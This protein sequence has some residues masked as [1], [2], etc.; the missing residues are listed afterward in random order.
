MEGRKEGR[1]ERKERKEREEKREER[2]IICS[3]SV[4]N[5]GSQGVHDSRD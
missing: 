3:R 1:K 5:T 4:E 2:E